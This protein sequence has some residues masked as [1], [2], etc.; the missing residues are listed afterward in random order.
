MA[1]G[2]R[3]FSGVAPEQMLDAPALVV[4]ARNFGGCHDQGGSTANRNT[5]QRLA[6]L[7]SKK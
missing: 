5:K 2:L 3:S 7:S 6:L 1:V 4:A